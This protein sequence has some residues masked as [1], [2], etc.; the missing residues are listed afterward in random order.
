MNGD[1]WRCNAGIT[2]DENK[3]SHQLVK[4][5]R[6]RTVWCWPKALS[7]LKFLIIIE[8]KKLFRRLPP[9]ISSHKEKMY[10]IKHVHMYRVG[11]GFVGIF[12]SCCQETE[13]SIVSYKVYEIFFSFFLSSFK[14]KLP[15]EVQRWSRT[16]NSG[17]QR[18][19][20][21]FWEYC[22]LSL[23]AIHVSWAFWRS[24]ATHPETWITSS[25]YTHFI[26]YFISCPDLFLKEDT[27]GKKKKH[28]REEKAMLIWSNA[29]V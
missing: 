27:W 22:M 6:N 1:N 23:K 15:S 13:N 25:H 29:A 16:A 19:A 28:R 7:G 18:P 14:F 21:V 5:Q 2:G 10:R 11:L 24:S 20:M 26:T 12:S 17:L 4:W 8:T 3:T 9:N